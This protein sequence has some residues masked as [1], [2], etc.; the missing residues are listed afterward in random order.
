MRFLPL[1]AF[2][3]ALAAQLIPAGQPVPK[4]PS[5]PVVFLNGYQSSCNGSTFAGTFGSAD[6]VLQ[7]SG[8][9]SLFF[10]NCTVP[11]KPSIEALGGAFG[12]FLAG[13]TY[14]A[15][16]LTSRRSTWLHIAW[17]D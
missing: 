7:A 9:V 1:F 6:A 10:D 12:Q 11:N 16:E 15:M 4:G 14:T 3:L 2:P 17:A 5:P 13:L 8:M